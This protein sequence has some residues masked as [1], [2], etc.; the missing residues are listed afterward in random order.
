MNVTIRSEV[1]SDVAAIERLIAEAF[2]KAPHTNHTEQ[3]IVNALRSAGQLTVSLAAEEGDALIGHIAVSP[4]S[5]SESNRGW[6]SLGPIAVAPER[7]GQGIGSLL[8][9]QALAKLRTLGTAGCVVLGEP[10]YYRRFGFK[11]APALVLPG[12]PP[13]YFQTIV[14]DGSIPSGTVSYHEAFEAR[15]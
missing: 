5:V 10:S 6:Y 3:F 15:S 9:E 2:L 12:V 11:V 13:E 1:A 7:Q 14:F 8:I 4:V